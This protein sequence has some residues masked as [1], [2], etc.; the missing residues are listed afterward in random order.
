MSASD[1]ESDGRREE[2][3]ELANVARKLSLVQLSD[4]SPSAGSPSVG[5][6]ASL[7]SPD[8]QP[9][10]P[11]TRRTR[12]VVADSDSDSDSDSACDSDTDGSGGAENKEVQ[13]GVRHRRRVMFDA[14][15]S[16]ESDDGSDVEADEH[17]SSNT[18][19]SDTAGSDRGPARLTRRHGGGRRG[20]VVACSDSDSND[21]D[22]TSP[23]VAR[24]VGR[25]RRAVVDSDVDTDQ[26]DGS[27]CSPHRSVNVSADS[28]GSVGASD[29]YDCDTDVQVSPDGVT[30]WTAIDVSARQDDNDH[31]DDADD[32]NSNSNSLTDDD[33]DDD[34]AVYVGTTTPATGRRRKPQA[35]P[36]STAWMPSTPACPSQSPAPVFDVDSNDEN[37]CGDEFELHENF[38]TTPSLAQRTPSRPPLSAKPPLSNRVRRPKTPKLPHTPHSKIPKKQ[39]DVVV[40]N[41]YALFNARVFGSRLPADLSIKWAPRLRK[42]AG[43]TYSKRS[44]DGTYSARI[45]LSPKVLDSEYR[46]RTVRRGGLCAFHGTTH[47]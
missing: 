4:C 20:R 29:V 33:D 5:S 22:A 47:V 1:A 45:E 3:E 11:T 35:T 42:T 7:E 17:G 23:D 41:A 18:P 32:S 26:D 14:A 12:R 44:R 15:S 39:R 37:D 38:P 28:P 34:D 43:L 21:S 40:K 36:A 19:P 25:R 16:C 30:A 46:V 27:T 6:P 13:P 2:D 24:V 10:L 8:V 31:S 9:A